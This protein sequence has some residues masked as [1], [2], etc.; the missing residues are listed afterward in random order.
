MASKTVEPYFADPPLK[1]VS[2][3]VQFEPITEL[4]IGYVGLIWDMFRDRYPIAEH[5]DELP[6]NIEKFGVIHREI[7]KM[8]FH[9]KLPVPR[10]MLTSADQQNIIQI[11]KD[12][13]VFNWKKTDDNQYPRYKSI[14]DCFLNELKLF[15]SFLASNNLPSMEFNQVE[16]T[17]VN[18][19]DAD[20]YAVHDVFK[21]TVHESSYSDNLKLENFSF[22]FR[23]I[24]SNH[25]E[26]IGR[27]YTNIDK[28][29]LV[30]DDSFVYILKFTAR[31]H[32]LDSTLSSVVDVMGIM[33]SEINSCFSAITTE[34][35]HKNWKREKEQS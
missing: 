28:G 25:K 33:R 34:Y 12:R 6:H 31:T 5:A 4:H 7:P 17:Y 8:T 24:I 19:I 2:F 35:M 10:M 20:N 30:S 22:K 27:M 15:S 32:P 18:H 14:K 3:S 11:Q 13:F 21:D 23:H 16:F 29:N 1:E 26:E 9:E